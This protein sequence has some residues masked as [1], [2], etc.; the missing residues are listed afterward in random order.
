MI[1]RG[2]QKWDMG[3]DPFDAVPDKAFPQHSY[4]GISTVVQSS[5][6]TVM[7]YNN[8]VVIRCYGRR[9]GQQYKD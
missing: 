6:D 4:N 5:K 3:E 7:D 2:V 1:M 8:S 9:N